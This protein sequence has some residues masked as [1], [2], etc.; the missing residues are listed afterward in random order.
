MRRAFW[1]WGRRPRALRPRIR[2]KRRSACP[3]R[4]RRSGSSSRVPTRTWGRRRSGRLAASSRRNCRASGV[5]TRAQT[6][7]SGVRRTASQVRSP[8]SAVRSSTRSCLWRGCRWKSSCRSLAR[9]PARESTVR[10]SHCSE[11]FSTGEKVR[12][13]WGGH[14]VLS[15]RAASWSSRRRRIWSARVLS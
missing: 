11:R 2:S 8:E 7:P 5:R 3:C 1:R 14:W 13:S 9:K 12:I 4:W 15:R 6:P 10:A